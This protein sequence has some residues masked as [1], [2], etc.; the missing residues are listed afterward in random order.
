M[1]SS[2]SRRTSRTSKSTSL[3]KKIF[4]KL[5]NYYLLCILY[6]EEFL[7]RELDYIESFYKYKIKKDLKKI[8]MNYKTFNF[9]IDELISFDNLNGQCIKEIIKISKNTDEKTWGV[10]LESSKIEDLNVYIAQMNRVQINS[11]KSKFFVITDCNEILYKLAN[12][13]NWMNKDFYIIPNIFN[14]KIE[15]KYR[16]SINYHIIS[17]L[18]KVISTPKNALCKHLKDNLNKDVIIPNPN[19]VY[20]FKCKPCLI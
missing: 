13:F 11:R 17:E 18:D 19:K 4:N 10:I 12:V 16:M 3:L 5:E 7:D 14:Y 9:N 1:R 20:S 8:P 15:E 6:I 2:T